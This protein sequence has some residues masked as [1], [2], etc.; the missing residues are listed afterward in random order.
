MHLLARDI[1]VTLFKNGRQLVAN[2]LCSAG[3]LERDNQNYPN[4]FS[5]SLRYIRSCLMR[6]LKTVSFLH[7]CQ[8]PRISYDK[9]C[10]AGATQEFTPTMCQITCPTCVVYSQETTTNAEC[11]HAINSLNT[12]FVPPPPSSLQREKI[13][14]ENL[15]HKH[16]HAHMHARTHT[17]ARTRTHTVNTFKPHFVPSPPPSAS[18][19]QRKK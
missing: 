4:R 1:L 2:W 19:R 3:L 9:A 10:A 6:H 17:R 12:H 15:Q 5:S 8:Y 13:E 14:V 16:M 18:L 11:I 7:A